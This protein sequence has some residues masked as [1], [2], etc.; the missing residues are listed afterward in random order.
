MLNLIRSP[1]GGRN[2]ENFGEDPYVVSRM[3]AAYIQGVQEQGIGACACLLVANDCEHRRHQTSSNMDD[4]T[5]RELHLLPYEMSVREVAVVLDVTP[6][7]VLRLIQRKQLPA[8][9]PCVGAPW[10]L[11]RTDVEQCLAERNHP[12]ISPTANSDQ[13]ILEIA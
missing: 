4:R 8:A 1:L 3:G 11:R 6:T 10:I 13:L 7:T 5:L 12:T 2:F 9:Q